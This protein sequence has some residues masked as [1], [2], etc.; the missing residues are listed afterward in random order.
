MKLKEHVHP[1]VLPQYLTDAER[2]A[3]W[4][5]TGVR[6]RHIDHH[7]CISHFQ[8]MWMVTTLRSLLPASDHIKVPLSCTWH[9]AVE[10]Y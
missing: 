7:V 9:E 6:R 3:R 10:L 1:R 2:W 8:L 5:K 4:G